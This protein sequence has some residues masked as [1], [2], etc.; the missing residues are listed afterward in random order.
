MKGRFFSLLMVF[1]SASC[2]DR[3]TFDVGVTT[4]PVVIDGSIS[5]QPGPYKIEVSRAFDIE[6]KVLTKTP[7]S[8]RNVVISDNSG[9]RETLTQVHSGQYETA[10]NGIQGRVGGVYKIQIE[11]L[12]GRIY[13]SKPDTILPQGSID[14]VYFNFK[15]QKNTDDVISYGFDVF[16]NSVG[17]EQS[18]NQFLWKFVGTYKTTT[19]PELFTVSCGESR[20]PRP[21]PCSSSNLRSDGTLEEVRPCVCCECWVKYFNDEPIVSDNQFLQNA[22]FNN[23]KVGYVP[24]NQWTFSDKVHAEARQMSLT[25]QAFDFWRAVQAQKKAT[26]SLFQPLAGKIPRNFI[27]IAGA[28]APVEGIFFATAIS[29]K[30]VFIT[31][32]DVPNQRLIPTQTLPFPDACLNL[33]PYSSTTQPSYWR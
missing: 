10:A 15:S 32:D 27:Q 31:R 26:T 5:N 22:R 23:I 12:D 18:T 20:C 2:V 30:A 6:S 17:A 14:S 19:N 29:T 3:I 9:I 25:K 28:E 1:L 33:F 21:L 4:Y 8:V 13:E 16:F 11:L 7:V 24:V